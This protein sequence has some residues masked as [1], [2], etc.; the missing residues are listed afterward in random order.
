M[1]PQDHPIANV[2]WVDPSTLTCNAYN[3][4]T[5]FPPEMGLLKLSII[6]DGW[7]QP[8]VAHPD[9]REIID[10]YHRW[11]LGKDD[12]EIR[13]LSGGLVP[14]VWTRP[15]DEAHQR[16]S[17]IRHNRARGHHGI[18]RMGEILRFIQESGMDDNQIM[19]RLGM[20]AEE[21]DRLTDFRGSD[22]RAGQDHFGKGWKPTHNA[23]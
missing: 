3:P 16:M 8:I 11:T 2:E 18:T 9:T 19:A 4:N 6:E 13:G 17:T 5:V 23:G 10:G 20:E 7:T 21:L 15:S 22:E 14:V 1:K 12:D